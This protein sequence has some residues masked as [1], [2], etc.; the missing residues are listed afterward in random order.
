MAALSLFQPI[1][2]DSTG[3]LKIKDGSFVYKYGRTG[4]Y[5]RGAKGTG[6][7]YSGDGELKTLVV[8]WGTGRGTGEADY[9]WGGVPVKRGTGA[10]RYRCGGVPV[11][12]S[13]GEAGY[14]CGGGGGC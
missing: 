5:W 9:W 13:T 8:S 14:R 1:H 10:A 11:Q 2:S 4:G 3:G 12:R 6:G 7:N